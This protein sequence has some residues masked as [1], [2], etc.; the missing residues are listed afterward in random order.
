MQR[1]VES[2]TAGDKLGLY[3]LAIQ[4]FDNGYSHPQIVEQLKGIISDKDALII[5]DKAFKGEWDKLYAKGA[6]LLAKKRLWNEVVEELSVNEPYRDV[7]ELLVNDIYRRDFDLMHAE[8]EFKKKFEIWGY[9][10]IVG[11]IQLI[12]YIFWPYNKYIFWLS[13]F[14][15]VVGLV[16]GLWEFFFNKKHDRTF[17]KYIEYEIYKDKMNKLNRI[18][19]LFVDKK[20]NVLNIY[21]TAG[22][23]KLD[24]TIKLMK[25]L[26][27]S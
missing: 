4:L 3:Q 1:R 8:D 27:D 19:S 15:G 7:I 20:Q 16:W 26:Q 2:F 9:L 25:A 18:Q 6:R 11:I 23:P 13:V 10:L 14:V 24:D 21:C 22:F 17:R 12:R 5:T